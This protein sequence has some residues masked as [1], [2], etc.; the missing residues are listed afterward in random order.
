MQNKTVAVLQSNYLPWKGYFDLIHDVDEFIFYDDVQY[1]KNDWRNRNRI[2][3]A[4]GEMW[5]TVPVGQ[6]INRRICDVAICQNQN[7]QE[8]HWRT[9]KQIYCKTDYFSLY[10]DYFEYVYRGRL[11]HSL[12]ELNQYIIKHIAT[13]CLGIKTTFS[14]SRLYSAEGQKLNRLLHL[15]RKA[16]ATRYISGPAARVYIDEHRFKE[17]NIQLLYKS[18]A[19]YPEYGQIHPPFD[20]HVSIV[21]LLFS[22]GP[23]AP[24]YIWGWRGG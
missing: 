6:A 19:G 16:C 7:W 11:W 17:N 10:K 13:E 9:L 23:D 21:D 8:K 1:T 4:S 2:H 20:H 3:T 5:L 22:V 12:S 24:Y 14:D 18:Y 15:L